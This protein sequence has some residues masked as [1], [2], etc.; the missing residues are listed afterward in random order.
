M[1]QL[2][3]KPTVLA[4]RFDG[5]L[6]IVIDV[7]TGGCHPRRHAL[8][9][10]SAV[11]LKIDPHRG[12]TPEPGIFHCHVAPFEGSTLDTRSLMITGIDPGHPFRFALSEHEALSVLFNFIHD[13][14]RKHH[15]RRAILVGHNA[16]FD[17]SF[18]K[19]ATRRCQLFKQDPFHSFTVFD[20]ATLAGLVYGK[21][22]LAKALQAA[23]I[24]FDRT[25]AHSAQYDAERTAELYC[26]MM[27]LL[28]R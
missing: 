11:K 13:G 7:E 10:I 12:W 25:Q 4:H 16:H 15:C 8:L 9:E 23:N 26:K 5:Y 22:V 17:L 1:T 2:N 6:P 24:D 20:T 21:T 14:L 18:I 3:D 19:A 28:E 27:N